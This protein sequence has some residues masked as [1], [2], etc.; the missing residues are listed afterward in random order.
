M[1]N[2]LKQSIEQCEIFLPQED[3]G[4]L[5]SWRLPNWLL[6]AVTY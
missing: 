2:Q 3:E 1:Y 4:S 5:L 6:L